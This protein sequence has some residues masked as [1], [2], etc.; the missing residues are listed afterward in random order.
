ME[1]NNIIT[2]PQVEDAHYIYSFWQQTHTGSKK[3][4]YE[5]MTTPSAEREEFIISL[6]N[7]V[8]YVFDGNMAVVKLG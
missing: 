5:F 7:E 2:A 6:G 3:A 8:D 4:F 1:S